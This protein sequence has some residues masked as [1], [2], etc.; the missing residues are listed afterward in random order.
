M[1]INDVLGA[2]GTLALFF[3]GVRVC[4]AA[5]NAWENP[6]LPVLAPSFA[7][8]PPLVSL[9]IPARNEAHN[10]PQTIRAALDQAYPHI[11]LLILDD[12]SED[13]TAAVVARFAQTD[14]RVRLLAGKPL[15]K[16]WLGKNWACHQL[17]QAA[18]GRYLLFLDADVSLH[19]Q[20][21]FS[22]MGRMNARQLN[23][24]SVFPDQR[25]ET[26]GERIVVPL[27]HYLLLTLLPLSWI[28]RM[29]HPAFAAANGQFMFFEGK[30]YRNMHWHK[31]VRDQVTEDIQ[32]VKQIKKHGGKAA[33]Y[34]G[35][36]LITCR[37]YPNGKEAIEGFSK[38]LLAGFGGSTVGLLFFVSTITGGYAAALWAFDP[39]QTGCFM[40]LSLTLINAL[41]AWQ[42]HQ[43]WA[44]LWLHPLKVLALLRIS[45]NAIYRTYTKQHRWKGRTLG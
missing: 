24:L 10:L 8:D 22:A 12:N 32:I 4:V 28:W 43:P 39:W 25:M 20:A 44:I 6:R 14:A 26:L 37:M 9:L 19:G 45:A 13:E 7:G 2:Y 29:R 21:I 5:L 11:E 42:S 31:V 18:R 36:R 3:L 15:P 38:N 17:G 41:I 1:D 23:L 30:G 16:G 34:L 35:N 27:M 40:L 33:T